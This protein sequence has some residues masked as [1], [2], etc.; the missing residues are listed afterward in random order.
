MAGRLAGKSAVI[1]G[2]TRGIGYAIAAAFL[3][4]GANVFVSGAT[5]NSVAAALQRL[6]GSGT[7]TGAAHDLATPDAPARLINDAV[8][9]FGGID[10][11]INNAGIV[12]PADEWQLT[13]AEWD[14]VMAVNTRAAFFA[15]QAAARI[16]SDG[17]GGSVLNVASIAGQTGGIAGSP[18]YATAKAAIIGLTRSLARRLAPHA[19]RVNAISPADIETDMTAGWPNELRER[20]IAFTPLARFGDADEVASAAVF[21]ASDEAS[22]ITGQTVNINGGAFMN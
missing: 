4:E 17:G 12:T 21:L 19:I 15:T 1:T 5:A 11:V 14:R 18:V 13:P 2:G 7:C 22:F 20:L 3:A 8:G 16:M 10:I 9:E 6:E